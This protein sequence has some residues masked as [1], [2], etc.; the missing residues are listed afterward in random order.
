MQAHIISRE[1]YGTPMLG[2]ERHVEGEPD[3]GAGRSSEVAQGGDHGAELGG[4][5]GRASLSTAHGGR[6]RRRRGEEGEH[7]LARPGVLCSRLTSE[8]DPNI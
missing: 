5:T 6:A 4:N 1:V 3:G 7:C 2:R 8:S